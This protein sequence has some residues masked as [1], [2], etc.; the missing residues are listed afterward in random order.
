M[1]RK[2]LAV[3]R[4]SA[5]ACGI[6]F[7]VFAMVAVWSLSPSSSGPDLNSDPRLLSAAAPELGRTTDPLLIG[8]GD[9]AACPA[10]AQ[11]DR[12]TK[13][14]LDQVVQQSRGPVTVFTAGDNAYENGS[15]ADYACYHVTWGAHQERTRPAAGNHEYGTTGAAGYFAYFG[16]AAGAPDQGY[17]SYDL[18]AWHIIVLNSGNC[19]AVSCAAGS[20]QEQWLRAD[21][22]AHPTTCTLAY[23]HHPLFSSG[24]HGANPSVRPLFQA[25]YDHG[26]DVVVN[27]H[28]HNYERF[29][30][31]DPA[32]KAA[33]GRGIRQFVIGTG[34]KTLYPW[35]R[36]QPNSDY[37]DNSANGIAVFVLHDGWYEWQF[38]PATGGA[39]G[40]RGSDRCV[41]PAP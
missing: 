13:A 41:T 8:A 34:G 17:Y 16:A 22:S 11:A 28:D 40:D 15:A 31:Q 3:R 24:R 38:L 39:A 14:L 29:A 37:R 9:I 25:L 4:S 19:E 23:W 10:G 30:L 35:G 21:L 27:G 20:P 26:V 33:P 18:G 5:L 32:G 36:L 12:A 7:A 6:L 2:P 1:R